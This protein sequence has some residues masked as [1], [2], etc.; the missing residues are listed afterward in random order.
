MGGLIVAAVIKYADN[1]LK[2]FATS[3]SI[4]LSTF[5]SYFWLQDFNP[6]RYGTYPERGGGR[7]GGGGA[8]GDRTPSDFES[9]LS[10]DTIRHRRP[11]ISVINVKNGLVVHTGGLLSYRS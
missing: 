4:M 10:W 8:Y 2:S 11:H 5:I 7:G 1:I 9:I 6:T 3:G